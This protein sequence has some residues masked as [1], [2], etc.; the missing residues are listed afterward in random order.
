MADNL[1]FIEDD[2]GFVEETNLN[3]MN[4]QPQVD[5]QAQLEQIQADY[6]QRNKEIDAEH[7]KNM[8]RIGLGGAISAAGGLPIL[9]IPYVGTGIGGALINAGDAIM[10]GEKL[11]DIAKKAGQGF[12]VGETIGAIPYAGKF[13]AKTKAGQ[14][15]LNSKFAN[16]VSKATQDLLNKPAIKKIGEELTKER[17][18]FAKNPNVKLE[19]EAKI[20]TP[21][22]VA[23]VESFEPQSNLNMPQKELGKYYN[24]KTAKEATKQI[25]K[26]IL[27]LSNPKTQKSY[28]TMS[29]QGRFWRKNIDDPYTRTT[30]DADVEFNN[31]IKEISKNPTLLND[32]AKIAEF[33]SRLDK[34]TKDL[35]PEHAQE[36][37]DKYYNAFNKLDEIENINNNLL[38]GNLLR[39]QGELK[40]SKLARS[41][42]L[43][44]ELQ[45][46]TPEYQVLHNKD[47]AN[48]AMQ[49]INTKGINEIASELRNLE[50][51]SALDFE[52]ARQAVDK[53]FKE[54]RVSEAMEI[55]E[56]ISE[57]GSKAGQAV[58]AM[59]L[60]QKTTPQGAVKTAQNIIKKYNKTAK[61]QVEELTENQANEIIELTQNIQRAEEGRAK[62]VATAQ[63][64]KYFGNLVPASAGNKIKTLRNISLLLNPKTFARNITGNAIFAGMENL[65]TKPI[66]AGLDKLASLFTKQRTRSLPQVNEYTKG[67]LQGAKEGIEDVALGIDTRKGIGG[68]FDLPVQRSFENTPV[69]NPLEK[70]LDYSLRVPDRAF[71]QASLNESLANQMK[72]AGVT[73]PTADML[74]IANEEALESVYQNNSGL[75]KLATKSRQALNS[76]GD[77]NGFGLG[78][79]LIPYAQTPANVAQQGI[80]YSPLGLVNAVKNFAEGNQRQATLDTARALTGSGLMGLGAFAANNGIINN[81]IDNYQALQN[82]QA[83][84]VRPNTIN[85]PNGYNM[86]FNQLQPLSAPISGGVALGNIKN[87]DYMGALDASLGSVA[88]LSMMRGVTDFM[89][90]Y[91][92]KGIASATA[93]LAL[94]IPSQ[95]VPTLINQINSYVDPIQRETYDSNPL[96]Q[97]GNKIM[98]R[99]PGL[100]QNLPV[101]YDVTGQPIQKYETEGLQRAF[102][103]F[104][105][106]VF[107]NKQKDDS[108][109]QEL[110]RIY[111]QTGD[112]SQLLPVADKKIKFTDAFGNRVERQLNGEEISRYQQQLGTVNKQVLDQ[113]INSDFYNMLDDEQKVNEIAKIERQV[114]QKV[115]EVLFDKPNPQLRNM[116]RKLLPNQQDKIVSEV[117][118]IY[119]KQIVTPQIEAVYNNNFGSDLGFVE[120]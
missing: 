36:Y 63:L 58:Q 46:L 68:R 37:W 118:K 72:A 80:N 13:A 79:A 106:P 59:S 33:E 74:K 17:Q 102:D 70:A 1:G 20:L 8:A 4:K 117:M 114:K 54:N 43:P 32:E 52:K 22:E 29:K 53:L 75:G 25:Q 47:L 86:S 5:K 64:M 111:E 78:D 30:Q 28:I 110:T 65:A 11:P 101:K 113:F 18:L 61:K 107:V 45:G 55:I 26:D 87:G 76:L 92:D 71:Y 15:L 103:T 16:K 60:W 95:F 48:N 10:E 51:P 83:M 104:A 7:R 98:S 35:Y 2:L 44:E 99:I 93:N 81:D 57:K 24:E 19:T 109:L 38:E 90:D 77:V 119:N 6:E 120:E 9:N 67:L 88:D 21:E 97:A 94:G 85:L 42:G 34:A 23:T 73:E 41:T 39:K 50:E 69:A 115:D 96:K 27:D 31:I 116:I 105:N 82:Y 56:Q 3:V 89:K 40:Q 49:E 108:T 14:A 12:V 84:G 66:A 91:N 62:D 100:S 112:K